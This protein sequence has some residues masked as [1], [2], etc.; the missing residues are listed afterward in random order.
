[1]SFTE[2]TRE[3]NLHRVAF[4]NARKVP[5][6]ATRERVN[7]TNSVHAVFGPMV[8]RAPA[9]VFVGFVVYCR[10]SY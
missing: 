6:E 1:V 10:E 8:K 9:K 2:S 7:E 5:R 4:V 3:M